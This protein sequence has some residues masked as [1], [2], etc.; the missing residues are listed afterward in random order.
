[1]KWNIIKYYNFVRNEELNNTQGYGT[2]DEKN[3]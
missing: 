1:M 3:T 2:A